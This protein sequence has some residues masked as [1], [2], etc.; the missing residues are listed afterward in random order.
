MVFALGLAVASCS[1]FSNTDN[2]A[3]PS[4]PPAAGSKIVYTAIGASDASGVGSSVVCVPFTDC[5]GGMGYVPVTV[6]TLTARSFTVTL[7]NLAIPTAVIGGDFQALGAQYGRQIFGNFIDNEMP[8]VLTDS[9]VTTVFAG[10]NDVVTVVSA[11]GQGAGGGNPQAFIDAQI[12]AFAADYSTLIS[13]IRAK[14]PG[15]YYRVECPDVAA[16]RISQ[17][18]LDQRQASGCRWASRRRR[19]MLTSQGVTVVDLMCD[20]R[21]SPSNYSADF[22][23]N[24]AG[25]AYQLGSRQRHHIVVSGAQGSCP[26]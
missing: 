26:R 21:L 18:A 25:Y 14:A 12:R 16:L 20:A 1:K 10:V 23:P 9:T 11:L 2:P 24:D 22:H 13:G 15:P 3:A 4:G 6:R 17:A 8:F 5:P 7:R 19:S